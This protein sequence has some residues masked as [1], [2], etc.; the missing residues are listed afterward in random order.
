[1]KLGRAF[2]LL[3]WWG[4]CYTLHAAENFFFAN[5]RG[6]DGVKGIKSRKPS[7]GSW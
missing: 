4:F 7:D 2:A 3:F 6:A 1:V 5:I